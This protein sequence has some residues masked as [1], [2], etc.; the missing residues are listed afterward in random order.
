MNLS[1]QIAS[2]GSSALTDLTANLGAVAV[3]VLPLVVAVGIF[4]I[5][6]RAIKP[7]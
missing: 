7:R 3:I 2:A 4:G 5:V 6:R 1:S